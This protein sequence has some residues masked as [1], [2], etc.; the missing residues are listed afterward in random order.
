MD[1]NYCVGRGEADRVSR[2]EEPEQH[3][4]LDG[5]PDTQGLLTESGSTAATGMSV[6]SYN[7]NITIVVDYYICYMLTSFQ[8]TF[9]CTLN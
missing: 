8:Q 7:T 6:G 4:V 1:T 5:A 2:R 3:R 9:K